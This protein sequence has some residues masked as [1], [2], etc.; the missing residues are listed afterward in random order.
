MNTTFKMENNLKNIIFTLTIAL[1][2]TGCNFVNKLK[3]ITLPASVSGMK[4]IAL[5]VYV[6]EDMNTTQQK[7][8][9]VQISQAKEYVS[10]IYG[11]T[12]STPM[13]YACSTKKCAN[14]LGIGARAYNMYN[15]IALSPKALNVALISHEWSHAELYKR[16]GGFLN[17]RKIPAWFDEGLAV[18]AS[19]NEPRHDKRAWQKIQDE[20]IPYPSIDE[21]ITTHQWNNATHK[22]QKGL[23]N[24]EI[25]VTYA[26]AGNIV[27]EWY[28][29]VGNDGLNKL[30][31]DIKNGSSF[32]EAY[33]KHGKL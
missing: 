17:W 9:L 30:F 14:A 29:K 18:V 13:I 12:I 20:N 8:L 10:D 7:H 27:R 15:H 21:L 6:D 31:E 2:F 23:N 22:Y 24:D 1:F 26:V 25:I 28:K 4:E 3:V 32:D 19:K 33:K 11:E 16:V 5:N